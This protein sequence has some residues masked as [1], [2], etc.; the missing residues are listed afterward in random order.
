[1]NT[2]DPYVRRLRRALEVIHATARGD[3]HGE[4][5]TIRKFLDDRGV[6]N[7]DLQGR[8]RLIEELCR[9]ALRQN[10]DE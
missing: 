10:G 9:Y 6:F 2:P 4:C 8:M 1:M 3:E 7:G 5:W